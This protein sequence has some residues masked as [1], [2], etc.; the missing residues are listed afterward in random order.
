M[1]TIMKLKSDVTRANGQRLQ[2]VFVRGLMIVVA[3]WAGTAPAL[4]DPGILLADAKAADSSKLA[5]GEQLLLTARTGDMIFAGKTISLSGFTGIVGYANELAYVV[6]LKGA[7]SL[8]DASAGA[9]QMLILRPFGAPVSVEQFDAIRLAGKWSDQA[10]IAAPGA[11]ASLERIKG[12]QELGVWFGRLGQTSFNVAASGS[13]RYEQ[14]TRTLMGDPAVRDIRFSGASDPQEVERLVV[15]SFLDALKTGDAKAAAALMDPTPFGGRA[16]A[17][18]ADDARLMAASALIK[19]RNWSQVAG[20][21]APQLSD[22]A[23]RAGDASLQLRT[24][25]DFVFV[26]RISGGTK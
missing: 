25:D 6:V 4:A 18:G 2:N 20:T 17:G 23:W 5:T 12:G 9:G 15:A 21:S 19:S 3:L 7:A 16:L 11:Y 26:S 24:I 8:T 13:A 1:G 22:G 14:Q 10:K